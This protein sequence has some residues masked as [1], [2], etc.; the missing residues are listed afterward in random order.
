[1]YDVFDFFGVQIQTLTEESFNIDQQF[2]VRILQ[3]VDNKALV[4]N[5]RMHRAPF[6]WT[7]NTMCDIMYRINTIAQV[8]SKT[9]SGIS[10][11]KPTTGSDLSILKRPMASR[12]V[13]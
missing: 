2:Y 6:S 12:I 1:M 3:L 11:M 8:T 13:N 5:C 7:S 4:E 9:F 10:V